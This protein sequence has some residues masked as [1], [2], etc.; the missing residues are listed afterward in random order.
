MTLFALTLALLPLTCPAAAQADAVSPAHQLVATGHGVSVRAKLFTY[1]RT[2]T[3]P[4]GTG[5]SL[6]AD[7]VPTATA[8]RVAV[9][10][11]G[12]VTIATGV[13][14]TSVVARYAGADGSAAGA[15]L[16]V[17]R[18]DES[19]RRFTVSLPA[20]RPRAMLLVSIRYG[21]V[22]GAD[23]KRESGDAHFSLGLREHRHAVR[24]PRAVTTR[25]EARCDVTQEGGQ[26][27]RLD[28]QGTIIRPRA[29]TANC[30]GG[31]M[32]IRILAN[33]RDIVRATVAT[34]AGCRYRLRGQAFS[35]PAGVDAIT[36]ETRFLGSSALRARNAPTSRLDLRP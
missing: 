4:Q 32:L 11:G 27:C 1:C 21:D 13:A 24:T 3:D 6:C 20:A 26:S 14:V 25:S 28:E 5:T 29:S 19:H 36:V 7:G 34:T 23:G 30:R 35:L 22:V 8:T 12:N 18:L 15:A 17:D 16:R 33:S 10:R 31:R 9:H 2:T